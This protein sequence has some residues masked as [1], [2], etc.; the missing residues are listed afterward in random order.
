MLGEA[1]NGILRRVDEAIDFLSDP[2]LP[3]WMS[4]L[5]LHARGVPSYGTHPV[6]YEVVAGRSKS[7]RLAVDSLR[8]NGCVVMRR[9][10]TRENEKEKEDKGEEGEDHA[11]C[12]PR[13]LCAKV[14]A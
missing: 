3:T 1:A 8:R 14:S 6:P 9:A 10:P 13:S 4:S 5:A 12:V 11:H 2:H 7:V